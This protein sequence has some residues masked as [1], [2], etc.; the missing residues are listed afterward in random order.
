MAALKVILASA[1]PRRKE[2]LGQLIDSFDIQT[3]DIDES[4]LLNEAPKHLVAR[5]AKEKARKIFDSHPQ[6]L[7]IGSDTIVALGNRIFGKPKDRSDS[8]NILRTLSGKEH[9]VLTSIAVFAPMPLSTN[10]AKA[11]TGLQAPFFI[12]KTVKTSI[13]FACLSDEQI[14]KYWRSGEPQDKAGSYAIQGLGGEF[15]KEIK[16]SYSSVVGLP[17]YEMREILTQLGVEK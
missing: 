8:I 14:I 10:T 13:E 11:S 5:L 4:P 17:L 9:E 2:L 7:V 15:V 1:S 6:H 12:S 3:A 16:G